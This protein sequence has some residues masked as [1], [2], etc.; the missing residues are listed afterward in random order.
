MLAAVRAYREAMRDFSGM[1]NLDVWYS[2]LDAEAI[3]ARLDA[4]L[5]K[6]QAKELDRAVAKAQTK[7]SMSAFAKLTHVVDG[8]LRIISDPPIMVPVEELAE[9][10]AS[11][12]IEQ[13]CTSSFRIVSASLQATAAS[14]SR[15]T[16]SS[17]S[18][19]RWSASAASERGPGSSCWLGETRTIPSSSRSRRRRNRCSNR[20][21]GEQT[22]NA[23]KRVVE[24][25]RLMQASSDILL[26]W[27]RTDSGLDGRARDFY[28]RQLWD[29][30]VSVDVETTSQRGSLL[31]GEIC[32]WTL[33]RAHA[34]SGD[35]IAI[36]SYLGKGD[37]FDR[38]V[39]DFAAAYADVNE[40]DYGRL[41]SAANDGRI[42][43][44]RGV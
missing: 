38:A 12:M 2:R 27:I 1:G 7:D 34:R 8:E 44:A 6:K 30:K 5:G 40:R 3:G 39:A 14:C 9:E 26:G 24:G 33:A 19:G 29:W 17:T 41:E 42:E 11:R 13:Q 43:V 36:A 28:V 21:S 16:A 18:L 15:A 37:V 10:V 35:R 20:T 23:G 31:Y 22:R 25:Q 4:E 32:G